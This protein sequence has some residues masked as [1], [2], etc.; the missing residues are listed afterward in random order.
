MLRSLNRGK[1]VRIGLLI[2]IALTAYSTPYL[3]PRD[4]SLFVSAVTIEGRIG[5]YWDQACTRRVTQIDWGTLIRGQT[6]EIVAYARNE[7]NETLFL[8]VRALNWN[9]QNAATYLKFQWTCESKKLPLGA[10][11]KVK[12]ALQVS[13]NTKGISSFKF[14]IAFEG[15]EYLLGDVNKDGIVNIVD[16]SIVSLAYGSTPTN[17]TW[18]PDADLNKDGTVGIEDLVTVIVDYG[19]TFP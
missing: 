1:L 17:P 4:S 11:I 6:K 10:I 13:S 12:P 7:G 9:P 18:N 16:L 19:K 5:V 8:T 15:Q 2:V 14:D 3:L